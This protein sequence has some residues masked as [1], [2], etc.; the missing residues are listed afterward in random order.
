[1]LVRAV[2]KPTSLAD[3][4][5]SVPNYRDIFMY[6]GINIRS[7]L[8][9]A[10]DIGTIELGGDLFLLSSLLPTRTTKS[11]RV[12]TR[13]SEMYTGCETRRIP[14]IAAMMYILCYIYI[15]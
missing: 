4:Y 6:S 1:M 7:D 3:A 11:P 9:I 10:E 5:H 13:E 15:I 2:N 14:Q 8:R 12:L